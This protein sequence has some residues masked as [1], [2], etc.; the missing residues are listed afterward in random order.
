M[1]QLVQVTR[2]RAGHGL[3]PENFGHERED[4]LL[5]VSAA[6]AS[7]SGTELENFAH[8]HDAMQQLVAEIRRRYAALGLE[9]APWG[10]GAFWARIDLPGPAKDT[11]AHIWLLRA[12]LTDFHEPFWRQFD[13]RLATGGNV[14]LQLVGPT[15]M[16]KSSCGITVANDVFPIKADELLNHLSIDVG[17]LPDKF[18]GKKP[19]QTV[20]FDELLKASGEGSRTGS[21]LLE[22]L[23]DTLRASQVNLFTCSPHLDPTAT[24]QAQLE[25]VLWNPK[26]RWSLFVVWVKGIPLGVIALPWMPAELYAVYKPW[27]E[28]NTQRTLQAQFN[29]TRYLARMLTKVCDDARFI[30]YMT[31]VKAKPKLK[32]FNK[33]LTLFQPQMMASSTSDKLGDFMHD[34]FYSWDQIGEDIQDWFGITPTPAMKQIAD[35]CYAE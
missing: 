18:R 24:T 29:D 11:L 25:V 3:L 4:M 13:Y 20:Q 27:K 21:M 10:E 16:A 31:K 33:A 35:K 14:H 12:L 5:Q 15:G 6:Y 1:T 17:E 26:E 34:I 19:G 32:D 8:W 9:G 22:N 28:A 7:V 2:K 23:D 30:K